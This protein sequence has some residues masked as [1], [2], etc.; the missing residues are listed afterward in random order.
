M[1]SSR[2]TWL[3][4][5]CENVCGAEKVQPASDAVT[6]YVPPEATENE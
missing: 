2:V 1:I 3:R 4:P 5:T 6:V